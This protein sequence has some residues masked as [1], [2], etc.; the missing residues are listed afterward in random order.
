MATPKKNSNGTWSIRVFAY[1]DENGKPHQKKFTA[2]KK[3]DVIAKARAFEMERARLSKKDLTVSEALDRYISAREDTLSPATI[4]SYRINEKTHFST[5]GVIRVNSLD[6][7]I[8]QEWINDLARSHTPK[9]V[10][11]IYGLLRSAVLAIRPLM[12]F[13]VKLPQNEHPDLYTPTNDDI[14]VLLANSEGDIHL[15]IGLAAFATLRRGEICAL[16][17]SDLDGN[18]LTVRAAVVMDQHGL[19]ITKSPKTYSSYRTIPLPP[20]L[21]AEIQQKEGKLVDLTPAQLSTKFDALVKRCNLPH[22]RFHDLRHYSASMMHA[23]G[24]PDQYIMQR[25]GWASDNVMKRVYINAMDDQTRIM[26]D[27]INSTFE[28]ISSTATSTLDSE[29]A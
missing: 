22:I 26:N 1:T 4:R 20:S 11:N 12:L 9:T 2:E 10:R 23:A 3:A 24:I 8:I 28:S 17:R 5:I 6:S 27:R 19:L 13:N 14:T 29:G 16:Q 18:N 25:G 7:D 21:V 15:A